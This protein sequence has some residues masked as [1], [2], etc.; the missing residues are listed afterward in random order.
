MMRAEPPHRTAPPPPGRPAKAK[1]VA[2][3][4]P[5]SASPEV[6]AAL[7]GAGADA[8]RLNFS[9]GAAEWHRRTA[10][11]VR[12]VAGDAPVALLADLQGPRI[13]IG[14]LPSP[15]V[16]RPDEEILLAAGQAPTG[17]DVLPTTYGLLAEDVRP[18]DRILIDNGLIELQATACDGARVRCR[19]ITGGE[20][21]SRKGIN[22]PGVAVTA[23]VP[24][25]K[26]LEDLAAA[27]ELGADYVA[28]SF[29]RGPGDVT[30][31]RQAIGARGADIPVIAKIERAEAVERIEEILAV[32]DGVMVARG[33]L[34]VELPQERV[35]GIQKRLIALA[36][37]A[38][39]PVITAT[40]MLQS[41]VENPRPTRAE[42]SDVA[43]A[44]LDGTD[45]VM[46]SGE[47][48]VGR[49][50][51]A[52]VETMERI[53]LEAETIRR[54]FEPPPR[55]PA[56][57]DFAC[58]AADAACAA[59]TKLGAAAIVIFTMS[60]RT[61]QRVAQ[62]R[63]AARLIALTPSDATRRRLALVWGVQPFRL[64][65]AAD[66]DAMVADAD[67]LLKACGALKAGD[68]I[69]IVGGSGPLTGATNF[70]KIHSVR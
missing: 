57:D 59:A 16:V 3:L 66:V 68:V 33:D 65:P 69:V 11:T 4:G 64:P 62:R 67:A 44:I 60:G 48:A 15:V 38:G 55:A 46:L 53:T 10:D 21:R 1:V 42:A 30:A 5:A 25:K 37:A 41:M 50:P 23:A 32:A 54:E 35:P 31:L 18:G 8:V 24:T 47:T 7:I 39:K 34:G 36:N 20:I 56:P 26:D 12:Q 58:A 9:H 17:T 49:H 22:L 70:T 43:N 2:T 51:V 40:E 14:A 6:I 63:P 27:V 29:V 61:A 13:R 19:V 28:M 52:A 45:A